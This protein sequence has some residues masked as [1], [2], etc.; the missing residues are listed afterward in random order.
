MS[1]QSPVSWQEKARRKAAYARQCR[2]RHV[3]ATGV[4]TLTLGLVVTDPV[5]QVVSR[6]YGEFVRVQ[7]SLH[8]VRRERAYLLEANDRIK[9]ELVSLR[10]NHSRKAQLEQQLEDKLS[11]LEEVVEETLG[12]GILAPRGRKPSSGREQTRSARRGSSPKLAAILESPILTGKPRVG[13]VSA[14]SSD[15]TQGSSG[16]GGAEDL[17]QDTLCEFGVHKE[18]VSL[19]ADSFTTGVVTTKA[20]VS[21]EGAS[22]LAKRLDH[23]ISVM[24]GLPIGSPVDGEI[25]SHYGRRTSPFS[26]RASFHHG[27]DVSLQVGSR[28]M[29]TG[30]GIVRRV[31]YNRTYGTL[32]DIE[33][34]KGLVT[35]YAHLAKSLVRPGQQVTRGQLIALS[36]S[37]GRSTGPHLHYEVIHNGTSRNPAPFIQLADRLAAIAPFSMHG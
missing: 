21:G 4:I 17:C 33:H 31:A 22:D 26:R 14:R 7:Q 1:L 20:S 32:I 25:T 23:A 37:T 12:L 30:A 34:I 8:D 18:D 13:D 11:A 28:V 19:A 3:L 24:K 27:I 36:G 5:L 15:T 10:S 35:R 29:S 9:T 2:L 6:V 16:V